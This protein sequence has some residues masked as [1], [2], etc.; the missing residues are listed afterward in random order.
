MLTPLRVRI[1]P[2]ARSKFSEDTQVLY[3]TPPSV[4]FQVI[5]L[6]VVPLTIIPPSTAVVSE[7]PIAVNVICPLPVMLLD[8]VATLLVMLTIS[9]FGG[10]VNPAVEVVTTIPGIK[11]AVGLIAV[12][13]AVPV[14]AVATNC[15]LTTYA[16]SIFLSAILTMF[17][18]V[19]VCVPRTVK[20]PLITRSSS[21]VT[22]LLKVTSKFASPL[23]HA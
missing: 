22:S 5:F 19:I 21:T 17:D 20:S 2:D 15:L 10:I 7:G 16:S 4:P 23:I 3:V 6:S 1:L 14:T 8:R 12:M 18:S 9:V 13:S 11:P